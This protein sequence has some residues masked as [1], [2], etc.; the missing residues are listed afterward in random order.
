MKLLAR[1]L[2]GSVLGALVALTGA[3]AQTYPTKPVR[4]IVPLPAGSSA[5]AIARIVM[6]VASKHLGQPIVIENEGGAASI[7]GTTRAS[8]AAPDGYTML[9]GNTSV[10][11]IN[12][13]IFNK[14]PYD[15]TKDFT[16]VART[17]SQGLIMAVP[18]SSPA[19]SVKDYVE[20]AKQGKATNYASLGIGSSAHLSAESL[21]KITGISLKHIPYPPGP[22]AVLDVGRGELSMMFYSYASF[23]PAVQAGSIRLLGIATE[24]RSALLPDLPTLREQGYDVVITAWYGVYA[25]A[26]TPGGSRGGQGTQRGRNRRLPEQVAGGLRAVYEG[27]ARSLQDDH[28]E[29]GRSQ[30]LNNCPSLQGVPSCASTAIGRAS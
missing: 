12:L 18:A 30:N 6:P 11:S 24:E 8:Q 1:L 15:P 2:L 26:G 16:A 28:R 3:Q 9:F 4:L 27:R 25:P 23:L 14:L 29:C 7:P 22:A 17:A 5:D 19:K 21:K 20:L 13:H 10:N